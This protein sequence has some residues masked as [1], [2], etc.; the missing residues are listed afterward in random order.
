M[1]YR[2]L[3]LVL[4]LLLAPLPTARDL[5]AAEPGDTL[6]LAGEPLVRVG[7]AVRRLL[8]I[9]LYRVSFY[10]PDARDTL[11]RMERPSV[12]KA[13]RV[14]VLFDGELP[15]EVPGKWAAKLLPPLAPAD[16]DRLRRAYRAL[17]PGDE[18]LFSFAPGRG[19]L[20]EHDGRPVLRTADHALM[21]GILDL[22]V[23][24]DAVS[25]EL[26]AAL[27]GAWTPAAP[28]R[29]APGR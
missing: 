8:W 22:F 27:L 3:A 2:T 1:P 16:Q 29:P 21:T 19:T 10:L 4:A 5:A 13:F 14:E 24:P 25:P 20:M 11:R 9:D 28:P 17:R 6:A 15:D 26:R 12:A 23:G 7:Q 18:L